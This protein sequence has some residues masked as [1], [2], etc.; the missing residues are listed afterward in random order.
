MP[1]PPPPQ[2]DSIYV[3]RSKARSSTLSAKSQYQADKERRTQKIA[4]VDGRRIYNDARGWRARERTVSGRVEIIIY[5]ML[6]YGAAGEEVERE[7][8]ARGL[9][10][11][12]TL[13]TKSTKKT[14]KKHKNFNLASLWTPLPT[15][16]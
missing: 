14:H 9:N 2:S 8:A 15:C 13:T 11:D 1:G 12:S 10:D 3:P 16:S 5:M 6:C 4:H 7:V